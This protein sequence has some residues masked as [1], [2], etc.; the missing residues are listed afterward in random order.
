MLSVLDCANDRQKENQK[1][2]LEIEEK[3]RQEVGVEAASPEDENSQEIGKTE[4]GSEESRGQ[5]EGAGQN[6][7]WKDQERNQQEGPE[8]EPAAGFAGIVSRVF[9]TGSRRSA[10]PVQCRK[11]RFRKC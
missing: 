11:C 8:P 10:G 1:E 7:F 5:E 4:S 3:S 6:D 9:G 2:V